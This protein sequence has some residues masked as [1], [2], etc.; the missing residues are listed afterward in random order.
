MKTFLLFAL[1]AVIAL[2]LY[3]N[4]RPGQFRIERHITINAQPDVIFAQLQNFHHWSSW[5]PWEKLDQQ[6]Q[7]EFSGAESGRGAIYSWSGNNKIGAGRMEIL[8]AT[9]N[10]QLLIQLDFFRPMKAHN[11]AHFTLLPQGESTQLSWAMEGKQPFLGKL[12]GL[13]MDIDKMVGKDFE[14]GLQNLKAICEQ[15]G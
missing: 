3:I 5:S 14:A 13:F 1:V 2:L 12:M 9:G 4:S 10:H 11:S 8:E 7:R 6:L 15:H